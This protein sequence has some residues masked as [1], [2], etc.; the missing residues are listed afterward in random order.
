MFE[1]IRFLPQ[2]N[3]ELLPIHRRIKLLV[4]YLLGPLLFIAIGYSIY[5]QLTQ[6]GD[7]ARQWKTFRASMEQSW[8]GWLVLAVVFVI[9]N[10]GLEAVKWRKLVGLVFPCS[11]RRALL[12][13]LAGVSFT[14]L[15]PNRVGEFMGR[16]LF[17]PGGSRMR[18]AAL[19][20]IGS[21]SQICIT[22]FAGLLAL[23]YA[24]GSGHLLGQWHPLLVRTLLAGC[25]AAL[26]IGLLMLYNAPGIIKVV[27]RWNFMQP[28]RFV[29]EA[30]SAIHAAFIHRLLGISLLR[31]IVFLLQYLFIYRYVGIHVD[32]TV[33]LA[34]TALM[35]T[36]IAI[37]PTISLAELGVRGQIILFVFAGLLNQSVPLLVASGL[38][39]LINIIL[40]AL[41]GS[42]MLLTVKLFGKT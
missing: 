38:V 30:L 4:N 24:L 13:V 33:L 27:Q 14:M 19:T 25:L 3:V 23:A 6:Q 10:W 29:L 9:L 15:T 36:L 2:S 34:G 17:M 5:R 28:Y 26:V 39:W 22:L 16:V 8:S 31:Y 1:S 20:S 12:S 42:L 37:V 7:L 41:V 32:T 21:L 40:P 11:Y 35:F 18:T